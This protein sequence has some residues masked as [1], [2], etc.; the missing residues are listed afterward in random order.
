MAVSGS[1]WFRTR[2]LGAMLCGAMVVA[3]CAERE[4][5]L[6]GEREDIRPDAFGAV[7][8]LAPDPAENVTRAIRL[9]GQ[10]SNST[11]A[12]PFGMPSN[13]TG[14]AALRVVP[15][16]VW[17]AS[18]GDGDGRRVRITADPVVAGGLIY[19]LDS[20]ARVSGVTPAGAVAWSVDLTPSADSAGQATGGGLS[21]ADGVLY[22]SSGYG[23][24]TALDART[25]AIRWEQRLE[26]AGSGTPLV[27]NGTIYL[28]S[29]DETGWAIRA[30]DGRVLWRIDAAPSVANVLGTPAPVAAGKYV[31]FGFGSGEV[32]G[33]FRNGGF[34][35]WS[36]FVGGE[37]NGRVAS[38]IGD[39]TGGPVL[40]GDTV[41][42]GNHSGR[43]AAF[44]ALDGERIWTARQGALGPVWPAGDSVFLVSDQSQL[45]RL[46]A[47]SGSTVWAVDLPGYVKDKPRKRAA[48]YAH[49]GPVLAGGRLVVASSDGVLR[50]FAPESGALVGTAE[51]PGGSSTSPVVAGGTLYI[52]SGKGQLLA[53]R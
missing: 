49:Y 26:A 36:A 13:R 21:Y 8:E 47:S 23:R 53:Y 32:V 31:I 34:E 12:Q 1:G 28:V 16:L 17:Q 42:A 29:G 50:F 9:P 24:L 18:I 11:W 35:R 41:Y 2:G 43:T 14:N 38:T 52:V 3:S 4:V 48:I 45:V 19:T 46:D 51:I 30:S 5:V 15:Q 39:I 37:R 33:A 44:S 25:G 10:V 7:A 22:V 40:V 27:D 20:G 6:A